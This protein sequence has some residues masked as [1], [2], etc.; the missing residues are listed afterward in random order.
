MA[1]LLLTAFFAWEMRHLDISTSFRDLYPSNHPHTSLFEK[2]PGFGSPL[3]V[4]LVVQVKSGSIYHPQTLGK[5][6][7]AT[8]LVD[9]IPGVGHDRV[10]SIASR[11]VKHVEATAAGIESTSL[12]VAAV[13]ETSEELEKL[14]EKARSTPGVM[15]NLVS[16]RE[17]AALIQATF[18][19]RLTDYNVLFDR[20]RGIM[21]QLRDENHELYAAGQ[22]MLT[23][24]VYFYERQMFLIF[25]VTILGMILL[26]VLH[27]RNV[28][29]VV[30]PIVASTATS[31]WGLGFAALFEISIDPLMMVLPMLLV[32]RSFS[33]AIQASERYFEIYADTQSKREAYVGSL[34]SLFPPGT[35]GVVTD[36]AG[37]FFIA[38]AP[39]PIMRKVVL[40]CGFWAVS[41]IPAN[42]LFTPL[43]LSFLPAPR[44]AARVVGRAKEEERAGWAG[45]AIAI[46]ERGLDRLLGVTGRL[47]QGR[48]AWCTLGVLTAV[49]IWAGLAA[50]RLVVGDANPGTSL[51]WPSSPYNRAVERI[52]ERFAG[53]DVLQVV[54]ES[55]RPEGIRTAGAL[56][57]MQRFQ[58]YME[59]DPEVGGTFSFA[60]LVP[61]VNRLFHGGSP[62]WGVIPEKDPDAALLSQLAMAGA[63]PGDF[64][65]CVT[66]DFSAAN[67]SVWY[68]NHR[69]E[70]IERAMRR[71][72]TF[73]QNDHALNGDG[74]KIHLASGTI[75]LLEAVNETVA[76]SEL[77]IILLVLGAVF[78]TCSIAY[79]SFVAALLLL[80]PVS[81]SNLIASAMMAKMEI[82]LDVNTLPVAAV[83]IGVGIDYAIYLMS[84][85]CE[86]Y[87]IQ[88][89]FEKAGPTAITTTGR[90]ILFTGTTLLIGVAPWY[91]LSGLR[92]QADMGLLMA[93]LMFINMGVA[94]VLLP[95]LVHFIQPNFVARVREPGS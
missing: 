51:L 14:R 8:R 20:V 28:A 17:D 25:A 88:R 10:L 64:D 80:V 84:R 21:E 40:V 66:T 52:N 6:Q 75:G 4:S 11:K 61:Q 60:D 22:P 3:T 2:Y 95:L 70:T 65:R 78:L 62:R 48:L 35:L 33:H 71:A 54:V 59:R 13:P 49:F 74:L 41:L 53:F 44:N 43:V 56:D 1:I 69:P 94:M 38:M 67:I 91:L 29:G 36:A 58:R 77:K 19:E 23:G 7:E 15:G 30:T 37:L 85:I 9:L 47:S 89:S 82:G 93:F 63:S 79:R 24:W 50:A 34:V 46:G 68:K 57:L 92:F 72:E 45:R 76:R 83:G 81:V 90:A 31:L 16:F 12:L 86:E 5:I 26:L 27:L 87:R 39:I 18:I 73:I 55:S 42:V 32:A